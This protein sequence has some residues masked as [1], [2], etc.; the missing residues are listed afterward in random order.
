M[1][2]DLDFLD[3][4]P[5]EENEPDIL[6]D[7]PEPTA[8]GGPVCD[9]CGD[10]IPYSGRGRRP[11][12]CAE[13]KTRTTARQGAAS[14]RRS[15]GKTAARITALENDLTKEFALFGKGV[16]K[17][18]PTFGVTVV[19]RAERTAAALARIAED[20]PKLMQILEVGTKIAPAIDLGETAAALGLALLVDMGRVDPDSLL[21]TM[22]EVSATWHEIN[23]DVVPDEPQ[24]VVIAGAGFPP[25]E[26]PLRFAKIA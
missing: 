2:D 18:L 6:P 13:H 20:N 22:F 24:G 25:Q 5:P 4:L 7:P 11:K 15:S 3:D 19:K 12:K 23:D 1:S 10:P 17:V 9:V 8:D 26:V 16:A 21:S 14:V